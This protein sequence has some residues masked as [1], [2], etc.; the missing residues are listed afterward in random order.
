M[1]I[2]L[3]VT[4]DPTLEKDML[5]IIC[6]LKLVLLLS[7]LVTVSIISVGSSANTIRLQAHLFET[8]ASESSDKSNPILSSD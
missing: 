6:T 5:D 3:F 4:E 7:D 8:Y 2:V 1:R